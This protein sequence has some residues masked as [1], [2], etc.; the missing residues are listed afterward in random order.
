[1]TNQVSSSRLARI[2][3]KGIRHPLSLTEYEIAAL[4]G[5]VLTQTPDRPK[6]KRRLLW[7]SK[8]K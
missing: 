4:C 2:A 6:K 1:M 5:S 3:A 7:T 8:R